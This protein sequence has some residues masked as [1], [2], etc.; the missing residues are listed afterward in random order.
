[1]LITTASLLYNP[2]FGLFK[3]EPATIEGLEDAVDLYT[4]EYHDLVTSITSLPI[5][6]GGI[7]TDNAHNEPD[8]LT[9]KGFTSDMH[10][11]DPLGVVSIAT[12]PETRA[13]EAYRRLRLMRDRLEPLSVITLLGTYDSMLIT[14]IRSVKNVGTGMAL[15]FDITLK[16]VLFAETESVSL[17][18][19]ILKDV[20][21]SSTVNA[22]EKQS[23]EIEG[24]LLS[25]LLKGWT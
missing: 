4:E 25:Q 15:V 7:L 21:Q 11:I 1:M 3:I 16:Q 5:E 9:M 18:P 13:K 2:S 6:T 23:P 22:G 8:T 10:A 12:N 14:G 24:S 20:N 19:A 17:P